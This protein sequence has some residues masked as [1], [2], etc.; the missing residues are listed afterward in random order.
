MMGYN[1]MFHIS[2]IW[3]VLPNIYSL[4]HTEFRKEREITSTYKIMALQLVD[5]S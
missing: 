5:F 4:S 1:Y 3:Y 2:D